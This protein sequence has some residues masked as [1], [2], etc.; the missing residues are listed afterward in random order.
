MK[1]INES[2]EM[3]MKIMVKIMN[4]ILKMKIMK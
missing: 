3:K 2:N 1:I 4:E